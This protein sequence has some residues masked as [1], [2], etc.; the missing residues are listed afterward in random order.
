[1]FFKRTKDIFGVKQKCKFISYINKSNIASQKVF[2]KNGFDLDKERYKKAFLSTG[3][4]PTHL[5]F[6][7]DKNK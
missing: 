5:K 6:I 3:T 4:R 7:K 2:M 1:M